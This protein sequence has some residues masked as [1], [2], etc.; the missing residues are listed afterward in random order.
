MRARLLRILVVVAVGLFPSAALAVCNQPDPTGENDCDL[1]GVR[2]NQGDCNDDG[3]LC[4]AMPN[5]DPAGGPYAFGCEC[6]QRVGYLSKPGAPE[7]CDGRNNNCDNGNQIDEGSGA[8]K[9]KRAC[10]T[11]PGGTQGVGVCR[12]GEQACTATV[13]SGVAAWS[14]CGSCP[15]GTSCMTQVLPSAETCNNQDDNCN[16]QTDESVTRGCYTGPNGTMDAGIC[17]GGT[18]ACA[19]GVFGACMGQVLPLPEACNNV[20]DDCNGVRDNGNPDGGAMCP[21]P[22]QQGVCATGAFVCTNGGLVCTQT[23]MP[24]T[25]T[26]NNRDDNCNGS[27]DEGLTGNACTAT[28]AQGICRNGTS[29]C[30]GVM[31]SCTPAAAQTETCNGLDDN[32]DGTADNMLGTGASCS[33]GEQGICAAGTQVCANIPADGGWGIRCTRTSAP[34]TETCN[35]LDDNCNGSTDEGLNGGACTATGAQGICRNGTQVCTSGVGSCMPAAAQTEVCNGLDDNCDGTVDNLIPTLGDMCTTTEPGRCAPGA[36]RCNNV[37]ADGGWGL[38]CVR[39]Q[40]PVAETCNNVDDNCNGSTDENVNR[41][42][43][44]SDAGAH[45]R[46]VCRGVSQACSMGAF[47]TCDL[48]TPGQIFPSAEM[49]DGLDNDCDTVVDDGIAGAMCGTGLPGICAMGTERCLPDAGGLVCQPNTAPG[50]VVEACNN[51]DDDCDGVVDDDVAV[52]RCF[53]GGAGTFSGTCPGTNCFPRGVCRA[54]AQ[55]CDG[56]GGW[57]PCGSAADA[58]PQVLPSAEVCDNLDNDCNGQVDNGVIVDVDMDSVRACGSCGALDAGLCDCNDMN[59]TIRP[60]R[61]EGCNGVDDN[62][63]GS[64]D[65][66]SGPGGKISQ[67]CYSGPT[68]TAGRGV[69]VQGT[70][71]CSA[72]SPNG[73]PVPAAWGMCLNEV[74]PSTETCNTR[75]DDCDGQTDEGFDVD[76]DGSRSCM[77]CGLATAC[78]CND[79]DATVRPGAVEL[80]DDV[81]QNCDGRLDD[82]MARTCFAGPNVTPD[83]FT[84]TCPGPQCVPKGACR[85]GTQMCVANGAMAQWGPCAGQ[86]LP[87]NLPTADE[88]LCNSLDDDCDGTV[89]DGPF[90]R[91][92]DGTKSCQG[93]CNDDPDGGARVRPGA[94][95]VCDG[96]DNNCDNTVDGTNTACFTSDAG[97]PGVGRCRP[98][99]A[100]CMNGMPAG[101]C[102]GEIGPIAETC[103]GIDD[104]CDGKI[105][106][107]FDAD[108]DGVA[109]CAG[110]CNDMDP[111]NKPDGGEICDCRDNDCDGTADEGNACEGAPCHDFDSDGYTNCQGDCNDRVASIGPFRSEAVGNGVDDDC[112]GAIDENTD[113][114]GDGVTTAQGDCDDRFAAIRP[115]AVE[116][117]DGFDNNCNGRV[118]EGFDTD[119]DFATTCGGDCD[120]AN[121]NK[122]PFR[123]EVCGNMLDDNCDGRV[124]ED[125][126]ADGDGVTTCQNDCNDFNA[127]VHPATASVPVSP[128]VCDGQDNDC[129]GRVD[130]G[131]D[132]D[133]DFFATCFGDCNDTNPNVNPRRS[134]LVGNMIDDD[135]DGQVDEGGTDSDGDGFSPICGDCNDRDRSVNPR[136]TE[137][138]DRV[139]NNCDAYVDSAPGRFDLCAVCFDADGDGQTNCDGDCNDAD[140]DVYRGAAEVCDGKDNDCDTE[141]DLDPV[142]GRRICVFDGGVDGGGVDD[143]GTGPMVDGGELPGEDGGVVLEDG[144]VGGRPVVVTGCGCGPSGGGGLALLAALGLLWGAR[145]RKKAGAALLLALSL[146]ACP[147]AISIPLPGEG[148]G[149]EVGGDGGPGLEDGGSADGGFVP[150][151]ASWPCPGLS[152]VEMVG[153]TVPGTAS[154]FASSRRYAVTRN[155]PAQLLLLDD[156][157]AD[158]AAFLAVRPVPMDVDPL[159]DSALTTVAARE[160]A[161]LSALQGSPLVRDRFERFSRVFQNDRGAKT[162][163]AAMTLELSGPTNAFALRNR[164]VTAL[165]GRT[166]DQLGTLPLVP[167]ARVEDRVVVYLLFRL[168]QTQLFVGAAVTPLSKFRQNQP[169]LSDL[170][171]GS[172]LS[173]EGAT[174]TY[175]CESRSAPALKTDFIFVV[176]SSG[177]MREE[178]AALS[179]AAEGLFDAF[180]QAGLDFRIG[181]ITTDSD[182][183]R[184]TG[185]TSDLNQFKSDVRVGINGNSFEMGIEF[186]LRAILR[187]RM[188][189]TAPAFKLRDDAGLVV[190]FVSDEENAGLRPLAGYAQ[191]Y[192]REEAVAFAI[193]G[194]RPLG[195]QRVGRGSAV[196]GTEY[197]DLATLTG[198][199]SGSI[200]NPNLTEVIEEVLFGALGASSGSEL[201]RRPVSGSLAVRTTMQLVRARSSGF[202]YDPRGN[203]ILFFGALPATGSMFDAAY[204]YFQYIQ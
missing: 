104:D 124:D 145:R 169:A 132:V 61:Q 95:E 116:V 92:M 6:G 40:G 186:G 139:D 140:R 202:D 46:G 197:I 138:C 200:C 66:G 72:I 100:V 153:V 180:A 137:V 126:D 149:G 173:G 33:T 156:A 134:E 34:R 123:R 59:A 161:A 99:M 81:D 189:S 164:L 125:S 175:A 105:D 98:G 3:A 39:N 144:G 60:N 21:V 28:T 25:E 170:T 113:E 79:N 131:F 122:S 15:S 1:D 65:E 85:S 91:D 8:G 54:S 152:P 185:F 49:C 53:E 101:T 114:D 17:R 16:M 94:L 168:T 129:N 167:G 121:P 199:S 2:V 93:D 86:V 196:A 18:Q 45:N 67:N 118:D 176:D 166:A 97:R 106:E 20:D 119:N 37:V 192:V 73:M 30:N 83:T 182:V 190:V 133:G 108:M 103:N 136:A 24:S 187:S 29:A 195:C 157:Q 55:T 163:S 107:D 23:V 193:V 135:C 87:T 19:A 88:Q 75:D 38:R 112:D 165:S 82:V 78:D 63:N 147:S 171:N 141:A 36:V 146:T 120:D 203:T 183:L 74:V 47:P 22:G 71:V 64:V 111:F 142:T 155:E 128:E 84:G 58:G 158:V 48:S 44:A 56:A 143:G 177:S 178:Q 50:S 41:I 80:C 110:D 162:Y 77:A 43:Y 11:G 7:I 90:D 9:L 160:V 102:A 109:T 174:F 194:P 4:P 172:H 191:E 35:N 127:S 184:G 115:N 76:G 96:V 5:C 62:C 151:V 204:A 27:T 13:G 14:T 68:G 10:Y 198:G 89:D 42:C 188:A 70:Q 117:C 179:D 31:L 69:C 150:P 148:D 26:C 181:V 159:M 32:C 57:N 130:E 154:L 52:R 51:Q 201:M 12:G